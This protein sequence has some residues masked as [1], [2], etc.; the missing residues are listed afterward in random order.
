VAACQRLSR[1]Y[2]ARSFVPYATCKRRDECRGANHRSIAGCNFAASETSFD[3]GSPFTQARSEDFGVSTKRTRARQHPSGGIVPGPREAHPLGWRSLLYLLLAPCPCSSGK[4]R[5][6]GV[7]TNGRG[8]FRK[9]AFLRSIDRILATLD[10]IFPT[11]GAFSNFTIA[12]DGFRESEP[13]QMRPLRRR[14]LQ[15]FLRCAVRRRRRRNA[16]SPQ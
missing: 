5:K 12:R 14:R 1:S 15:A 13:W 7:I 2:Q 4:I 11:E 16:V 10:R 6:S 9:Y 3:S 8:R